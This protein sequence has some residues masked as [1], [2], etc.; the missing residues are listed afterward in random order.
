MATGA[1][2][3]IVDVTTRLG[4]DNEA[5]PI[6]E[7]LSQC[8]DVVNDI[9][10]IEANEVGGHEF[11][12][13]TSI[14]AGTWRAYGQG[15]PFGKSTTAKSRVGMGELVGYSQV[16]RTLAEDSGNVARFRESEDVAFLEGLSQTWV[17]TIFYGNSV[18]TPSSFQGLAPFY[19]TVNTNT[20]VNAA[21]VI[22]GGGTGN[23]NASI[24]GIGWGDNK[25]FGLYP[26]GSK[27][28]LAMED[29]GD[30]MPGLDAVGNRYEAYTSWFRLQTS[31]CPMDWR[32][33][34]RIANID[35]TSAGLAGSNALDLFATLG[36]AML[37]PPQLSK[38]ASGITKTDAPSDPSPSMRFVIYVNRTVRHWMDIQGMRNRNVLL[39]VS[40]YA[41]RV[42]D[43]Y[44]GVKV[45]IV[46]QLL[47]TEARVV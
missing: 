23:N 36:Q 15:V 45:A 28:G 12:F 16:D 37:L 5:L 2:P 35:T 31:L 43:T 38:M 1:W 25:I 24:W 14:P 41:G 42:T 40:D 21:A 11:A 3:S 17:G 26:R 27:A 30:T 44:R 29:K 13:R 10:V 22:D 18:V 8:N 46:D 19:N 33:A 4:P 34:F 39:S 6:A 7:M 32:Y 47:N 20:A 9:P